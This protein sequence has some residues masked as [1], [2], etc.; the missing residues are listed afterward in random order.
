MEQMFHAMQVVGLGLFL[1]GIQRQITAT[2]ANSIQNAIL[3]EQIKNLTEQVGK[4]NDHVLKVNKLEYDMRIAHQRYEDLKDMIN[5]NG[6]GHK[7]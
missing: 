3:G 5:L 2:Q 7:S 4:L 6:K 1:W